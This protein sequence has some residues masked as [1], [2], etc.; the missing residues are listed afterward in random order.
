VNI[1][2]LYDLMAPVYGPAWRIIR[3]WRAY[4]AAALAWLPNEA[5]RA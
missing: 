3:P 1:A 5:A 4:S 2:R